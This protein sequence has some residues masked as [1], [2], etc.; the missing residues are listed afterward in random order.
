VR[1]SDYRYRQHRRAFD[2]ALRML[3]HEALTSTIC[4]WTGL[5]GSLVRKFYKSYLRESAKRHRGVRP[6][7]LETFLSSGPRR[8]DA[9]RWA[10]YCEA[11]HV[12]PHEHLIDPERA[13]P[14]IERGHLLCAAFERF[15]AWGPGQASMTLEQAIMLLM[16][17][18]KGEV[19]QLVICENCGA[20]NLIDRLGSS[21]T[22]QCEWCLA[23]ERL[24]STVSASAIGADRT[25]ALL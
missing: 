20:R 6:W 12:L 5:S 9:T 19:V 11:L 8:S 23:A 24:G 22:Q 3:R 15:K 7:K 25:H 1:A 4:Q 18:A 13:L 21:R 10:H 2:L 14:S 17:F 16:A